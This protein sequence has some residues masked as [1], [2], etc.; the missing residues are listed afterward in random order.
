MNWNVKSTLQDYSRAGAGLQKAGPLGNAQIQKAK[1]REL[2]EEMYYAD[3]QIPTYR[4]TAEEIPDDL[5]R[6][7]KMLAEFNA[8]RSSL[9][10]DDKDR[11][12]ESF[13]EGM[14]RQRPP[15]NTA[16]EI[17]RRRSL[18]IEDV[19]LVFYQAV[20]KRAIRPD[21][22]T[23]LAEEEPIRQERVDVID[24]YSEWFTRWAE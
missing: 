17:A 15:L 2:I 22:F 12:L 4:V 19:L 18:K 13:L 6:N 9:S 8:I 11:F 20:S 7:L 24:R 21:L 5:F 14:E 1:N 10:D 3:A 16:S 23:T